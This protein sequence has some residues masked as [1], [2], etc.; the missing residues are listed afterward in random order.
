MAK[1]E[2]VRLSPTVVQADRDAVAALQK[3]A[4]YTPNNPAYSLAAVQTAHND[5]LAAQAAEAQ[6]YAALATARDVATAKEWA[7]H[8]L[9]LGVK[10]QVSGQFGKN[11]NE[12]QSLGLK[13]KSEYKTR[14][15][16][17]KKE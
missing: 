17:Q 12:L 1:N 14:G 13:K 15:R 16:T 6:A 7:Y 4:G 10:D 2:H 11:S 8:N 5:M 9:I 3:I